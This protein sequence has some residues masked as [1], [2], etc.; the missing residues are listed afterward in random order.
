M[1]TAGGA[2]AGG[3]RDCVDVSFAT[4]VVGGSSVVN[5]RRLFMSNS[6]IGLFIMVT[7]DRGEPL[8]SFSNLGVPSVTLLEKMQ[9]Y[10]VLENERTLMQLNIDVKS[11]ENG[12]SIYNKRNEQFYLS[13]YQLLREH[14]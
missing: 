9:K 5:V 4:L 8:N 2:E 6:G 11:F 12:R 7:G 3:G 14:K 13:S 1:G 10:M